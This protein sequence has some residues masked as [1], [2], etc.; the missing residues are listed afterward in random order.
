MKAAKAKRRAEEAAR[1][2]RSGSIELRLKGSRLPID[3]AFGTSLA[4][5]AMDEM[6]D[7]QKQTLVSALM[8][9]ENTLTFGWRHARAGDDPRFSGDYD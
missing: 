5:F 4:G 3:D 1:P 7:E 6:G 2:K 9:D 8:D